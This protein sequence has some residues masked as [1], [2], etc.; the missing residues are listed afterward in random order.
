M[1]RPAGIAGFAAGRFR[2]DLYDP[3]LYQGSP[4]L[5]AIIGYLKGQK[6]GTTYTPRW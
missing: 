1:G 4:K 6:R 3:N 2:T 5:R